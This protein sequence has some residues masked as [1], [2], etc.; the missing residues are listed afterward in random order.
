[1]C[2]AHTIAPLADLM[3]GLSHQD[4]R[5]AVRRDRAVPTM[6]SDED[7]FP[8]HWLGVASLFVAP[9]LLLAGEMVKAPYHFYF[10]NQLQAYA[11]HPPR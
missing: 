3:P 1:M 5:T 4:I 10:P 6:R 9:V 8:G 2:A 11:D 7:G